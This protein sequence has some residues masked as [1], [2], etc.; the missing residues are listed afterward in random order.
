VKEILKDGYFLCKKV[1]KLL[2]KILPEEPVTKY[3][4]KGSKNSPK[5]NQHKLLLW[6]S[7]YFGHKKYKMVLKD[8]PR[9]EKKISWTSKKKKSLKLCFYLPPCVLKNMPTP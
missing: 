6:D 5:L 4:T 3:L 1:C 2:Y 8:M 9:E 7:K